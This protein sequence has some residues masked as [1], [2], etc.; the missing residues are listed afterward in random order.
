MLRFGPH[1]I[2]KERAGTQAIRIS[3]HNQHPFQSSDI[4]HGLARLGKIWGSFAAREVPLQVAI[5]EAR[6]AL[7][8]KRVAHAQNDEPSTFGGVEN[9]GAVAE[10]AGFAAQFADLAISD[11]KSTRLNSSHLVIS[12]AV[13]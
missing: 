11:R 9:A 4:A 8:G 7:G 10:P 13:F 2:L 5:A 1:R 3:G 6:L 12:Y